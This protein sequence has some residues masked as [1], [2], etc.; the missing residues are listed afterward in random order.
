VSPIPL[1]FTRSHPTPYPTRTAGFSGFCVWACSSAGSLRGAGVA[2]LTGGSPLP[3]PATPPLAV[4][5]CASRVCRSRPDFEAAARFLATRP[6]R[7]F[8]S[9][10]QTKGRYQTMIAAA[11]RATAAVA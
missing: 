4:S 8:A 6:R 7:V 1:R 11:W 3:A 9:A 5:K 2:G 10:V